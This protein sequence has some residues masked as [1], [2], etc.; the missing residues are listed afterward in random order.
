[1]TNPESYWDKCVR[2]VICVPLFCLALT[3]CYV[4][5]QEQLVRSVHEKVTIGMP[6]ATAV[7]ALGVDGFACSG[8]TPTDCSRIKQRLLPSSCIERVQLY[9]DPDSTLIRRVVVSPI[10][11][12]GL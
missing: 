11:C 2:T 6:V 7:S 12:A 4:P 8:D 10:S 3:A 1:M 5:N 9:S